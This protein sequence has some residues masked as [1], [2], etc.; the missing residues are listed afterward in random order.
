[1]GSALLE[2]QIVKCKCEIY[3][4]V[5]VMVQASA[6]ADMRPRNTAGDGCAAVVL[7][8]FHGR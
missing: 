7:L 4:E 6:A 2:I 1:M 3:R 5:C 8:P